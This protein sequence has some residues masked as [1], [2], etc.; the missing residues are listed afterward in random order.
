MN[1]LS[2]LAEESSLQISQ[3]V[4]WAIALLALVVSVLSF[5]MNY[6]RTGFVNDRSWGIDSLNFVIAELDRAK[7]A[8]ALMRDSNNKELLAVLREIEA[9]QGKEARHRAA[10]TFM[11]F[12]YAM[13]RI[14]AA[15]NTGRLDS[16]VVH[17]VW[18]KGWFHDRFVWYEPLIREA[19]ENNCSPDGYKSFEDYAKLCEKR[20]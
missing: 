20:H 17:S 8:R 7:E 14:C 2:Q 5:L 12:V 18:S 4:T 9:Q 11:Q 15:L 16:I 1:L 19:R 13:N 3:I 10:H 6:R